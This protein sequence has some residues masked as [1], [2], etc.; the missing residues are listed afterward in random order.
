[1]FD[2]L[3]IKFKKTTAI[4]YEVRHTKVKFKASHHAASII[5]AVLNQFIVICCDLLIFVLV[6]MSQNGV[7]MSSI[8]VYVIRALKDQ[9]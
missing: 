8:Y 6:T 5:I 3:K 1:M 2:S 7:S 9:K 4:W